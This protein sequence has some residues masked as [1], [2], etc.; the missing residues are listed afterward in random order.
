MFL[1]LCYYSNLW[2]C[3]W[4][5]FC[6]VLSC[7]ILCHYCILFPLR[8]NCP[9]AHVYGWLSCCEL[10]SCV[11]RPLQICCWFVCCPVLCQGGVVHCSVLGF[12]SAVFHRGG[13]WCSLMCTSRHECRERHREPP[14]GN[15]LF[16]KFE[17]PTTPSWLPLNQPFYDFSGDLLSLNPGHWCQ[18]CTH[19]GLP[20]LFGDICVKELTFG[21]L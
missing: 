10:S 1:E 8:F 15:I 4:L 9:I 7:V 3:L 14:E 11:M 12:V 13:F 6:S 19:I 2:F 21:L 20:F 5:L 18:M 17:V 16:S